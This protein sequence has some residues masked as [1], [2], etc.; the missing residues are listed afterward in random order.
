[1]IHTV[2][3]FNVV[4][5]AE[6]HVFMEFPCF[7][8]DPTDVGPSIAYQIFDKWVLLFILIKYVHVI[9]NNSWHDLFRSVIL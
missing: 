8:Y 4:N 7:F 6:I 1:M 2:K 5:E 3:A 9:G